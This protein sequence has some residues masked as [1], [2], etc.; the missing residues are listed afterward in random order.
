MNRIAI[1]VFVVLAAL[2]GCDRAPVTDTG[3]GGDTAFVEPVA[4]DY[5]L[6]IRT[7]GFPEGS[8]VTIYKPAP[9]T[10]PEAVI[11]IHDR[12]PVEEPV[13]TFNGSVDEPMIASIDIKPP[14]GSD[15]RYQRFGFVLEPGNIDVMVN[16][17]THEI[18]IEGGAYNDQTVN[19]WKRHPAY[20]ALERDAKEVDDQYYAWYQKNRHIETGH[21]EFEKQLE[22][23]RVK[24]EDLR[25]EILADIIE[26]TADPYAKLHALVQDRKLSE[27][28]YLAGLIELE[29]QLKYSERWQV[30]KGRIENRI[31]ALEAQSGVGV[32]TQIKDFE[33]NHLDGRKFQLSD[34]L[35]TKDYILVEFWASW[36]G[37]CRAEIPHMKQAYAEYADKG[38]EILSFSLDHEM[39]AWEDASIQEDLPWI[40]TGD[41]KAFTSP[42]AKMYGVLAIPRNYLVDGSNGEIVAMDLRGDDLDTKLEEL[43]K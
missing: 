4:G 25:H 11:F 17:E 13:M 20:L 35:G 22:D 21:P 1:G 37:P 36:C 41:L 26:G 9:V 39:E 43:L 14:S 16:A 24:K 38:F 18:T 34:V 28:E 27:S 32:G 29:P 40:N 8:E 2:S 33:A 31:K 3:Q 5:T 42:V 15:V 7:S 12:Q 19:S 23:L 30:Y 6:T 10:S